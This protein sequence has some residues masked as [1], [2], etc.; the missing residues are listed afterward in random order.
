[1]MKK[2]YEVDEKVVLRVPLFPINK[3]YELFCSNNSEVE[4]NLSDYAV[5]EMISIASKNLLPELLKELANNK[6]ISKKVLQSCIKYLIRSSSRCTPYGICAGVAL[7]EMS[8]TTNV[9]VTENVCK[10]S[11]PDMGWLFS[12]IKEIEKEEKILQNLKI[13]VNPMCY[14]KSG[15]IINPYYYAKDNSHA[16]ESISI[17][18]TKQVRL[19]EELVKDRVSYKELYCKMQERNKDVPSEIIHNFLK[20]LLD[21]GYLLT[22]LWSPLV[23]ENPF[24][25]LIKKLEVNSEAHIW[26]NQLKNILY[27]LKKYDGTAIGLGMELR[28]TILQKM[29]VIKNSQEYL[30]V[31]CE[32]DLKGTRISYKIGDCIEETIEML[33]KISDEKYERPYLADYKSKFLEKY[34]YSAAVPIL[35][36][37][38]E[39]MGIGLPEN[40]KQYNSVNSRY[41]YSKSHLREFLDFK[42]EEALYNNQNEI[43][44]TDE[45]IELL[46]MQDKKE[47][48]YPSSLEVCVKVISDGQDAINQGD[49]RIQFVGAEITDMAGKSLGRFSGQW[50]SNME[51]RF[52]ENRHDT[53]KTVKTDHRLR[54]TDADR[55]YLSAA[56]QHR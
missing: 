24:E 47:F 44:L 56:L 41:N 20:D 18:Y 33:L 21:K 55:Q 53:G 5:Q 12:V 30:Q 35:E 45:D 50:E 39:D 17:K 40:Y 3:Y 54:H 32:R 51:K 36:L 43:I 11:R 1:M 2:K 4:K 28:S 34:G 9:E 25:Y 19:V 49:F 14:N 15:R 10:R 26:H 23:N 6:G 29:S 22:E 7:M 31:D 27:E 8:H 42:Y 13:M 38:D 37:L 16:R 52:H 48:E 46:C